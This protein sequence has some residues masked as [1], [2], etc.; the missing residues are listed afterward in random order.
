MIQH[1]AQNIIFAS[2]SGLTKQSSRHTVKHLE[3]QGARVKVHS[4]DISD[5]EHLETLVSESIKDMPPIR[6]VVQG[7][8]VLR[9]S[10]SISINH[11]P[12]KLT[13]L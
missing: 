4:C 8:M 2:R 6:G 1:G 5:P 7:A 10:C 13:V 9:V 3:A 12:I 11:G